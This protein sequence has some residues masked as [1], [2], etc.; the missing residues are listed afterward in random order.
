MY[1][2]HEESVA[3]VDATPEQVFAVLDDHA[4]LSSHMN[5]PSWRMGGG[6]METILDD[7]QGRRVGSHIML[8]GRVFGLRLEVEEVVTAHERPAL[9]V[10]ETIGI[11]RLLVIG[12]Y[13]MWFEV[14]ATEGR[15]NLRV[16]IDYD[17]P[18]GGFAHL[19]GLL[20]GAMYARWC[21]RQM[22][23]DARKFFVVHPSV[24]RKFSRVLTGRSRTRHLVTPVASSLLHRQTGCRRF[25]GARGA[26]AFVSTKSR[27]RVRSPAPMK[28][29]QWPA[30]SPASVS[31]SPVRCAWRATRTI[32]RRPASRLGAGVG[33]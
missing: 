15:S 1:T 30:I 6:S 29:G 26:T 10:W 4:R 2:R 12:R 27:Q 25:D 7:G 31:T 23:D 3:T 5:K 18:P 9:K 20:F 24:A 22:T 16:A 19:L 17:V 8:R 28:G 33:L 11:P 14:K 13:R 32:G 21:T